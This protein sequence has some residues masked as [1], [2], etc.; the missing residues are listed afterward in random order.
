MEQ[1]I[2]GMIFLFISVCNAL[3][4]GP[5]LS[6]RVLCAEEPY[7]EKDFGETSIILKL[8]SDFASAVQKVTCNFL[9]VLTF[10][11]WRSVWIRKIYFHSELIKT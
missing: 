5:G 9:F 11:W 1:F 10:T 4:S 6:I 8:L 2:L 7:M 3:Y